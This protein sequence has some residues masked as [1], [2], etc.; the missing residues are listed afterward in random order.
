[1][2]RRKTHTFTFCLLPGG[3]ELS[4]A[5]RPARGFLRVVGGKEVALKVSERYAN[6]TPCPIPRQHKNAMCRDARSRDD[7]WRGQE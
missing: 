2:T 7:I 4:I 6:C 5:C 1:M 3:F